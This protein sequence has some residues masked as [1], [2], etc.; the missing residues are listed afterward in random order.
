M[1]ILVMRQRAESSQ[2][3]HV[4]MLLQSVAQLGWSSWKMFHLLQGHK[5]QNMKTSTVNQET[6]GNKSDVARV[7]TSST[8]RS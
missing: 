6:A 5:T 2:L 8:S 1:F 3:C 4:E 7:S